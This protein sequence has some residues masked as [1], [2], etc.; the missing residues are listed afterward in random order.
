MTQPER[1]AG[2]NT[3]GDIGFLRRRSGLFER[4]YVALLD[5]LVAAVGFALK[6]GGRPLK[7][8][9][10]FALGEA[11]YWF[12]AQR[13]R[14]VLTNLD[15]VYADELSEAEKRRLARKVFRH[16]VRFG[17]DF[18]YDDLYWSLSRIRARVTVG[19]I[20]ALDAAVAQGRG[21]AVLSGHLGNFELGMATINAFGYETFG[22]YKG[23]TNPWFDRFIGKKR[24]RCGYSLVEVPPK[25]YEVV[26][27][28]R[29]RL[30]RRSVR[31]EIEKIWEANH[32]VAIAVDQYGGTGGLKI[33]FLGVP[34]APT[35]VGALRYAVENRVPLTLQSCVY[36]EGDRLIWNIEGPILI[37][38]QPGGPA[39]TLEHYA[40]LVNDWF[41]EQ[42]KKW[43]EQYAWMHRRFAHHYYA[44]R[45]PVR[46]DRD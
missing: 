26:D 3:V 24:L 21:V 13:R 35:T 12:L 9:L 27:G 28:V 6:L 40:R 30:P 34:D 31:P 15:L 46:L 25:E 43:P 39:A 41:S 23:F 11:A 38:D 5:G 32:G 44:R 14:I 7:S 8:V 4:A 33:P 45:R 42:I 17:L 1:Q 29:R 16:Q 2:G 37:E 36:G 19:N 22:I 10:I 20:R 18:L